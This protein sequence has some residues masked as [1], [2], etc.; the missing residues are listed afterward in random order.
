MCFTKV[1]DLTMTPCLS[2]RGVSSYPV[3]SAVNGKL[4]FGSH[5]RPDV[6]EK[7]HL[8]VCY[9]IQRL[10]YLNHAITAWLTGPPLCC[11]A[12]TT[13]RDFLSIRVECF[14]KAVLQGPIWFLVPVKNISGI[15]LWPLALFKIIW[16]SSQCVLLPEHVQINSHSFWISRPVFCPRTVEVTGLQTMSFVNVNWNM[17]GSRQGTKAMVSAS[18][19]SYHSR[20]SNSCCCLE[21]YTLQFALFPTPA[22][23]GVL[24]SEI[25]E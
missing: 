9:Q 16:V 20:S 3:H 11:S 17:A 4:I 10:I 14:P 22:G 5:R 6:T 8:F 15:A 24:M 12:G 23:S 7:L 13:Q 18:P 19:M 2:C 25:S 21:V 1:A